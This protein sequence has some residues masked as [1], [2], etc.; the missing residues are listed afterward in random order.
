MNINQQITCVRRFLED[1]SYNS[2]CWGEP[3]AIAAKRF[4]NI[5]KEYRR[6]EEENKELKKLLEKGC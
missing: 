5:I 1:H 4:N 2:I 6:L 3:F